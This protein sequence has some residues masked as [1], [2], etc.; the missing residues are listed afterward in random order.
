[1]YEKIY[2]PARRFGPS[3]GLRAKANNRKSA[4]GEEGG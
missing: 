1:L 3:G 4:C 2:L